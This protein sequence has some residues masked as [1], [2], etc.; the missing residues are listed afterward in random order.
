MTTRVLDEETVQG[1]MRARPARGVV[2]FDLGILDAPPRPTGGQSHRL[3]QRQRMLLL[4]GWHP[5]TMRA[6][7]PAAPPV[8][9]RTAPGPR[10]RTCT[11]LYRKVRGSTWLKCDQRA[12]SGQA[13]DVRAWWPACALWREADG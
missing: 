11:H 7:H 4:G 3:T 12:T 1:Y 10:C 9:D 6:L 5:V 13:T 8:D 2:T